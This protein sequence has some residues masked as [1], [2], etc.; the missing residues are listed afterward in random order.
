[1]KIFLITTI[2]FLIFTITCKAQWTPGTGIMTTTNSVGI[3]ATTPQAKL[4]VFGGEAIRITA[5]GTTGVA[6]VGYLSIYDPNNTTRRGY[7]GDGST[8]NTDIYLG[9]DAGSGL[10][11]GT[12]G[13]D[14]R[15]YINTVGNVGIGTTNPATL[16]H[17]AGTTQTNLLALAEGTNTIGYLGRGGSVTGG[18]AQTPDALALTY[19]SRDLAIGGWG[20]T[21]NTWTGIALYIN[22]DNGYMG[23]GTI[24]PDQ[25]LTVN[26]TIHSKSVLVDTSVPVPDYVFKSDYNLPPLAAIKTYIDKNHHLP[27]VPAAAEMEKNGLNLGEM[28]MVLL[29]KVEEL[30][31]YLIEQQKTNQ[32]LQQQ[33]DVLTKRITH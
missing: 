3:G 1:M 18:Y 33:I 13:I 29:K 15:M 31:L 10:R 22:S 21:N 26:G 5:T 17:V 12:N 4:N 23:V 25:K 6:A 20:K 32:S 16:L 2:T 14:S 28:N 9:A 11:F 19:S 24:S 27:G 30:T 7:F 8:G